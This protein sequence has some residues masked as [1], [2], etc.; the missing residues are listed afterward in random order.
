MAINDSINNA[1]AGDYN[2]PNKSS[3]N[4]IMGGDFTT[5][6]WQRGTSFVSPVINTNVADRFAWAVN[7]TAVVTITKNAD[8][9]TAAQSGVFSTS[10]LQIAVTTADTVIAATDFSFLRQ[11]IEG[12]DFCN[13]AQR[14]FTLSFWVNFNKTGIYCINVRNSAGD[15]SFVSEFTVNSINTWEKKTINISPSPTAGT[16]NYTNGIGLEVDFVL[17]AGSTFSTAT[18]N[19]WQTGNFFAST[20]QVNGVDSN[21]NIFKFA[22]IQIEAGDKATP[23]E[24]ISAENVL[25]NCQRYY[26]KTFPQ[27]TV[28]A[29][30][31]GVVL[32]ACTYIVQLA[33]ATN[34]GQKIR[35]P[36]RMRTAPTTA[37]FSPLSASANWYNITRAATTSVATTINATDR[38]IYLSNAQNAADV[39]GN[40]YAIHLTATAEL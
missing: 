36:V 31:S 6:P 39:L 34:N 21:T 35:Y 2:A 24:Q 9:P 23:F 28:P 12:Y 33:G 19:V 37:G 29:Q 10:C 8:S 27:A 13:I 20:N 3:K 4:I 25:L 1:F 14:N 38:G 32:G 11:R 26:F 18:L 22:L 17:M 40:V 5:N 15:R 7:G 16:W 30:N